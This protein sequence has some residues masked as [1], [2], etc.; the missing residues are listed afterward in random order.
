[1]ISSIAKTH[2]VVP[3]LRIK[4]GVVTMF[5]FALHQ[6]MV[7]WQKVTIVRPTM[8][9]KYYRNIHNI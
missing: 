3:M 5:G 8:R 2:T 7:S 1:M 9:F 4:T 6:M